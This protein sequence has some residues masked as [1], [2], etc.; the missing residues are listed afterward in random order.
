MATPRALADVKLLDFSWSIA[1]PLLTKSFS[2]H[3]ATVVKLESRQ[4][5]DI[6][7]TF[8]P[9]AGNKPGID[10]CGWFD[11]Y[12]TGK[13]SVGLNLGHPQGLALA[14]RLVAWADVVVESFTAGQMVRW[15]LDYADLVKI[16]PDI[17]MLSASVFGQDGPLFKQSGFGRLLQG[18]SGFTQ[19]K[20]WADRPPPGGDSYTD[21]VAPWYGVVSILAALEYRRRSGK[22]QYIDLSQHEAGVSFLVPALLDYGV[23]GRVAAANGNR[24]PAA[25]PHGAF[26]CLGDDKWCTVSVSD[27]AQWRAF[28]EV[29]GNPAWALAPQFEDLA[30]RLAH[31]DAL[32][33]HVTAWTQNYDAETVA[34]KLQAAGVPAYAVE[35]GSDLLQDAQLAHRRHYLRLDHPEMGVHAYEQP[36]FRLSE[37]PA[38]IKR[39]PLFEE[40]NEYVYRELLG[41][42]EAEFEEAM[43]AGVLE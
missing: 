43:L 7:R 35:N 12:A 28:R 4:R 19:V 18:Y 29:L 41:L 27:E 39:S 14:R 17:I 15:G 11:M 37:T 24:S 33:D 13:L 38:Q 8:V 10:R 3:G 34:A 25:A 42:T 20:G 22:G 30:A 40:H 6:G 31:Q 5:F 21:F 2:D 36:A 1:G 16:K 26:R 23:N 32:E 9:M